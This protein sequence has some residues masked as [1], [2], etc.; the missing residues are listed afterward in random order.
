MESFM[1]RTFISR[2]TAFLAPLWIA[3]SGCVGMDLNPLCGDGPPAPGAPCQISAIWDHQI[4]FTADPTHA[5]AQ[6]PAI[7]GR[8]YFW[9][10]E[11][12]YPMTGDGS[13]IVMVYDGATP[14]GPNVAPL[15]AWEFD[16]V[17][18]Q[19]LLKRDFIGWG[20]TLPLVWQDLPPTLHSVRVKVC[21]QPANG[22]PLYSEGEA[23]TIE[24]PDPRVA[25]H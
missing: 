12:K 19:R 9:G 14:P 20:Y 16:P 2:R 21:Y 18:L 1:N 7:G 25:A 24:Y 8:V 11:I 6:I 10:P 22:T 5:G 13:L 15:Q 3:L 17:T 4:H 23:M